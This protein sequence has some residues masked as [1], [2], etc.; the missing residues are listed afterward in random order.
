M[1]TGPILS[2]RALL[3]GKIETTTNVD[4]LPVPAS[5]AFLVMNADVKINP[6][7][8]KRDFY[9]PSLSPLATAVGRKLATLSFTHEIKGAGRAGIAPKLATLLRACGFAQTLVANN[10]AGV[11]SNIL[12]NSQNAGPAITWTKATLPTRGYNRYKI[13]TVL[14]GASA[15]AKVI[16]TGSPSDYN[17]T[18]VLPDFIFDATI[19]GQNPTTTIAVDATTAPLTPTF[20]VGTPQVG[21]IV[22]LN[23][24]GIRL[25]YTIGTTVAA[26]E[27]AA[28]A[29][30]LTALADARFTAA[31]VGAV[32]TVTLVGG[33]I[34]VTTATTNIP[35]GGSGGAVNMTWTGNLVIG[36]SWTI[37]LLKPGYH[38]QPVSGGFE[39]MTM[40]M[41][42]DG[43]VHRL[44]GCIGTIVFTAQA[45]QYGTAAFT[46][47]GQY[48]DPDDAP[49][50]LN[51]TFEPST[52]VQ[53]E[54]A[55]LR[56]GGAKNLAA[57]SFNIDM[58]ITVNPRDS[59]SDPDGYKGVLYSSRE[60]KG[61]LNPEMEYESVEPYW[62]Y[63]AAATLLQFHARV[64]RAT[65]NTV[66]FFSN[67]VQLSN[68]AYTA[69]NTQR[70]YD[71]SMVFSSDTFFGDDEIRIVFS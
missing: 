48:H 63:M 1:V 8:L 52:P 6:N 70:V 46:F 47:T 51:A 37:D 55:Q 3:L 44:T 41:F 23:I 27:G 49:L 18:T 24:G 32:V 4:S 50:P 59:V 29:A 57:Q 65:N 31:A 19:M 58:G 13:T 61:G 7:V 21:D 56:L 20:T 28:I 66:E 2:Q 22:V 54:L 16:V 5:D 69:R 60:P 40:Y 36:D 68:I 35:L 38:L 45:G 25:K 10:L 34:T 33:V 42:Y 39:S 67:T 17:D 14:G 43:T 9:R 71:L 11:I 26:T 30:A 53:V 15:T 62:R 64:G 12:P